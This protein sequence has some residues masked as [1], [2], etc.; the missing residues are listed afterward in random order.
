MTQKLFYFFCLIPLLGGAQTM[1]LYQ[2]QVQSPPDAAT[3]TGNIIYNGSSVFDSRGVTYYNEA[4]PSSA[5]I[6]VEITSNFTS[7]SLVLSASHAHGLSYSYTGTITPG[8]KYYTF[9]P[10]T[11]TPNTFIEY[12]TLEMTVTHPDIQGSVTLRPRIDVKSLPANQTQAVAITVGGKTWMDRPLGAHRRATHIYDDPFSKGSHFQ[13]GRKS[14]GHEIVVTHGDDPSRRRAFNGYSTVQNDNPTHSLLII[15][16]NGS[17]LAYPNGDWRVNND[18]S[19]WAGSS[20]PNN[21]CPAGY[22]VPTHVEITANFRDEFPNGL[23]SHTTNPPF[24]SS[25]GR[26]PGNPT[27]INTL[28]QTFVADFND[29]DSAYY[30]SS[31]EGTSNVFG[32]DTDKTSVRLSPSAAS[33]GFTVKLLPAPL[34]CIQN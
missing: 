28:N 24:I 12:G 11:Y 6:E 14:D 22:R 3:F 19:I 17:D 20:A 31:N 9:T 23:S 30:T 2:Y 33:S 18:N 1:V 7:Q 32:S 8:T 5:T 21:P 15:S 25:E 34:R 27:S 16:E 29:P 4:V 10:N 13:W 26:F